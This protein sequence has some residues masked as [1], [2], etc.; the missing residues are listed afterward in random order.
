LLAGII[1]ARWLGAASLGVLS[2][3]TV[4]TAL[5]LSF[6]AL[7]LPSAITFVV[8]RD[9]QRSRT[10]VANAILMGF[11]LGSVLALGIV[12]LSWLRPGMFGDIPADL[13]VIAAC[14]IPFQMLMLFSMAV[15]LGLNDIRRYNLFDLLSQSSLVLNP[16][17]ALVLLGMGLYLLVTLNAAAATALS[18]AVMVILVRA[19]AKQSQASVG[20]ISLPL[21]GEL[22]KYG[23]KFYISM[24][25]SM[26]ILRADL[27]IVNYFSGAAEAGVYGV[28]TQVATVFLLI[29]NVIS[30]VLFPRVTEAR[31]LAGDM[32]CRV[33][34][35]AS[36]IMLLMCLAAIPFAFLLPMLYGASFANVPF[37]VLILLP[38][39][40]LLGIETVQ[41]QFFNSQGVPRAIPLF[42]VA[43]TVINIGLNLTLVPRFGAYAAAAVST[44]SYG[45]MFILI[46]TYFRSRTGKSFREAFVLRASELRDG[47]Q[48][49][50]LLITGRKAVYEGPPLKT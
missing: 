44:F 31:D 49:V 18:I 35:H 19:I 1:V 26:I 8:A 25:A 46:S 29:P 36:F 34:R 38:G 13:I 7:G 41:V 9:R 17:I 21:I 23:S 5:A 43:A 4:I 30:I 16:V 22:L 10:V 47:L 20:G 6:G 12:V 3:L 39:V 2:S 28:S 48:S 45:L 15:F 40:Y 32:T 14:A 27:L 50:K 42:W 33:T 24:A 11:I 37:Q